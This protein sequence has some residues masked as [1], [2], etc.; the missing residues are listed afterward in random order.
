MVHHRRRT[1]CAR[2]RCFQANFRHDGHGD[3]GFAGCIRAPLRTS[4]QQRTCLRIRRSLL[5]SFCQC[6]ALPSHPRVSSQ[7]LSQRFPVGFEPP[8]LIGR[9]GTLE[10][11]PFR[12]DHHRDLR[13][14]I[15]RCHRNH[16]S[17]YRWRT[18]GGGWVRIDGAQHRRFAAFRGCKRDV[19][20]Q[21]VPRR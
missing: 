5:A 17:R 19:G 21:L 3:S 15:D 10:R 20:H 2:D 13:L 12:S 14:D 11:E 7:V 1:R 16:P 9:L 18:G 8:S 6:S 4:C